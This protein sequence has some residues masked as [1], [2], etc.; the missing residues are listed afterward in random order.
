MEV[1]LEE[2][3]EEFEGSFGDKNR[4]LCNIWEFSY[5]FQNNVVINTKISKLNC[6]EN[7]L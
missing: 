4:F 5:E 1:D 7:C 6:L 3:I 2:K